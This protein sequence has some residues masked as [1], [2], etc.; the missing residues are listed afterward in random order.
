MDRQR[1]VQVF[2]NLLENAIQHSPS[3]GCVVVEAEE[4]CL[5]GH[6]WMSYTITGFWPGIPA[7]RPA[8]GV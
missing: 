6:A 8:A 3:G 1:L 7:R 5:E 4:V 2:Q